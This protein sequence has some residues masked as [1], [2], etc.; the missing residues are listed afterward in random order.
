M[1]IIIIDILISGLFVPL[2]STPFSA[3]SSWTNEETMHNAPFKTQSLSLAVSLC[4]SASF[5]LADG[6]NTSSNEKMPLIIL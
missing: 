3:G 2:A 4:L 1:R 6:N 5:A